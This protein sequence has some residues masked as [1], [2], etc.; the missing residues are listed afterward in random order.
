MVPAG[1]REG[2]LVCVLYGV[3]VPLVTRAM[4]EREDR[5]QEYELVGECYIH[6]IM[7]GEAIAMDYKVEDICLV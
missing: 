3:G 7:D 6:G 4:K 5:R 2:D 1:T